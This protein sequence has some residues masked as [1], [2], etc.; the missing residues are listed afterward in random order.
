MSRIDSTGKRA[1]VAS[2]GKYAASADKHVMSADVYLFSSSDGWI[3][4]KKTFLLFAFYSKNVHTDV[5]DKCF[6]G[7]FNV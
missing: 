4:K 6:P 1:N 3:T 5:H 7:I 2:L